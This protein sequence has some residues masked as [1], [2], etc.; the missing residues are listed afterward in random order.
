LGSLRRPQFYLRCAAKHGVQFS[1]DFTATP[2]PLRPPQSSMIGFVPRSRGMYLNYGVY[3]V[4]RDLP[5][6]ADVALRLDAN[7]IWMLGFLVQMSE[8]DVQR[9]GLADTPTLDAM[10]LHLRKI[11]MT[12]E[13]RIPWWNRDNRAF[14]SASRTAV[15]SGLPL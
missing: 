12:F 14:I 2:F 9:L 10:K 8:R 15:R 6:A 1:F 13:M 5:R 4:F 3:D 11:D 7:G